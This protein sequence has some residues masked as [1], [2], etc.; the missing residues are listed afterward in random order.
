MVGTITPRPI[1]VGI[2][3]SEGSLAALRWALQEGVGTGAPVEVVH[4]WQLQT[5]TDV[6]FATAHEI[7]CGSI[8]MVANE[9]AAAL[10]EMSERPEVTQLSRHGRPTMVLLERASRAGLLV[11]GAHGRSTLRDLALGQ[12]AT[13]ARRHARCPV[14]IV[15]QD[16]TVSRYEVAQHSAAV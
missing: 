2:D 16:Q 5:V 12:V 14:M 3:G 15:Q 7:S 9:V 1:V 10:A 11:L 8:C 13:F 6:V 4:C